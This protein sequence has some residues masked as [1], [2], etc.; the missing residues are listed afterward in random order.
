MGSGNRCQAWLRLSV[1]WRSR[2][3]WFGPAIGK[4]LTNGF[5]A[6]TGLTNNLTDRNLVYQNS[7]TNLQP[8]SPVTVHEGPLG[9]AQQCVAPPGRVSTTM[10]G[11]L[12]RPICSPSSL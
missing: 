6:D 8:L 5:S 1:F 12:A 2:S 9:T 3:I 4:H 7:T 10:V 11:P